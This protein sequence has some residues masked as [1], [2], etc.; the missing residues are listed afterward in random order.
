MRNARRIPQKDRTLKRAL[1]GLLSI[2]TF[3]VEWIENK[4]TL[5]SLLSG[6]LSVRNFKV[7]SIVE[8]NLKRIKLKVAF[9]EILSRFK[10]EEE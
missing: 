6:K 3:R 2:D 4:F 1:K 10:K 5:K 8:R 9:Q 7:E